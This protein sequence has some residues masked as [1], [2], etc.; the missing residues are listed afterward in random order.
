M[1]HNPYTSLIGLL[2]I[3]LIL[4]VVGILATST[5][6][7]SQQSENIARQSPSA[8]KPVGTTT[9]AGKIRVTNGRRH[10]IPLDAII[11]GGPGKDG[12]PSIDNP[13]FVSVS[14]AKAWL[15]NNARGIGVEINE[16][17]RF[18]PYAILVWHE[19]VNDRIGDQPLLIT[20]CPLCR[21]GI[22]FDPTV[23]GTVFEFGVSGKLWQSN[24]LMYNRTEN[25]DNESYWSQVLGEAVVGPLTGT[26]L[27]IIPSTITRLH[28][29]QQTHPDTQVLARPENSR[30]NYNRDPYAGHYTSDRV[31]FGAEYNDNRLPAKTLVYGVEVDETFKAYPAD[32]LPVGTTTDTVAGTEIMITREADDTVRF[33]TTDDR[34]IDHVTGFWF[35]W[36]AVHPDTRIFKPD[37]S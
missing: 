18:Y 8:Q 2:L 15:P 9:G 3:V 20:Y 16:Q 36:A 37:N 17:P 22:V 11:A 21:T 26:E 6:N 34:L 27:D 4:A 31:S 35:S 28:D 23:Q 13:Q 12:I 10:S 30:R 5:N 24:L 19:I 7:E 33:R 25:P 29:W 14:A 32:S 1:N